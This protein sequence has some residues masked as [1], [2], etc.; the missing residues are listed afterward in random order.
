MKKIKNQ[1]ISFYL[2]CKNT[3]KIEE[4]GEEQTKTAYIE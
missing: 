3:P 1:M 2:R 4:M